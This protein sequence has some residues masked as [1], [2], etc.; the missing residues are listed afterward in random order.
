MK[1]KKEITLVVKYDT[2]YM[3]PDW[4]GLALDYPELTVES[5]KERV[6]AE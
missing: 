6:I 4:Y 3:V 5:V 2:D 1:V